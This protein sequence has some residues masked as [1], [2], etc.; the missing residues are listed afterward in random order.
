[1]FANTSNGIVPAKQAKM[2][3]NLSTQ[4]NR[5]HIELPSSTSL[6]QVRMSSGQSD[7]HRTFPVQ[8]V[9]QHSQESGTLTSVS[10]RILDS[11]LTP[12]PP[13]LK[14]PVIHAGQVNGTTTNVVTLQSGKV[15]GGPP[16]PGSSC[17]T[18]AGVFSSG[19]P[20]GGTNVMTSVPMLQST[21]TTSVPM[22]SGMSLKSLSQVNRGNLVLQLV[23]LYR[24]YQQL[25]DTQGMTKVK[26][27]LSTFLSTQN[28]NKIISSVSQPASIPLTSSVKSNLTPSDSQLIGQPRP[29]AALFGTNPS[30]SFSSASFSPAICTSNFQPL[31]PKPLST[32]NISLIGNKPT[33]LI[34]PIGLVPTLPVSISTTSVKTVLPTSLPANLSGKGPD[35]ST[36][37]PSQGWFS[38]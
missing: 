30:V 33:P 6:H 21:T 7:N 27:Q 9:A 11:H 8:T 13:V 36:T 22:I 4:P 26:Q 17:A 31:A 32:A 5:R 2:E 35:F 15:G 10:D 38:I 37:Q 28:N 25:G 18:T 20:A 1:M 34:K 12:L 16:N 14:S 29:G 24:Q 3:L 23:Q 19:S